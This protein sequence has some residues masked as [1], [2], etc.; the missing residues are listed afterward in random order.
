MPGRLGDAGRDLNKFLWS[1][2]VVIKWPFVTWIVPWAFS[3]GVL[4]RETFVNKEANA[5]NS[6]EELPHSHTNPELDDSN[7]RIFTLFGGLW[8]KPSKAAQ[9][10]TLWWWA[11]ALQYPV[12]LKRSSRKPVVILRHWELAGLLFKEGCFALLQAPVCFHQFQEKSPFWV[13]KCKL[14]S[15]W[16]G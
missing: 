12:H 4:P 5:V 3:R 16:S 10:T 8:I 7:G 13:S 6:E 14:P 9:M 2:T 11:A 15:S 1:N